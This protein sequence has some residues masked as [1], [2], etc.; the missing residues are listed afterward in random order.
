MSPKRLPDENGF[1]KDRTEASSVPPPS[2]DLAALV[3]ELRREGVPVWRIGPFAAPRVDRLFPLGDAHIDYTSFFRPGALRV[4]EAHDRG[5]FAHLGRRERDQ[6]RDLHAAILRDIGGS[7]EE[8]IA[9]E[10]GGYSDERAVR[11]AVSRGRKKWRR[12][13]VW[14]WSWFGPDG[15]PPDDWRSKGPGPE[16]RSAFALWATGE[17]RA[18]ERDYLALA[19]P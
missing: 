9:E 8:M 16:L 3:M 10:M 18:R 1:H 7:S 15:R 12:L 5:A 11:R 6:L 4:L 14:P 2:P 13:P 17:P 19:S